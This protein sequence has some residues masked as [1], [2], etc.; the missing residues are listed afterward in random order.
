MLSDGMAVPAQLRPCDRLRCT[1]HCDDQLVLA[2]PYLG[3]PGFPGQY[4]RESWRPHH[5][6]TRS[7]GEQRGLT[8]G[9]AEASKPVVRRSLRS[10]REPAPNDRSFPS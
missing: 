7:S 9:A 2:Y 6:R 8:V 10:A 1:Q 5:N 3:H 4:G